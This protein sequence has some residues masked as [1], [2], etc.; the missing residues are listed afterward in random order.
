MLLLHG[1]G[2]V[3][4]VPYDDSAQIGRR[5]QDTERV[6]K[7]HINLCVEETDQGPEQR[8]RERHFVHAEWKRNVQNRHLV[9]ARTHS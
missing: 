4:L 2:Y 1:P 7:Q 9:N 5:I 8:Q 6:H 3:R